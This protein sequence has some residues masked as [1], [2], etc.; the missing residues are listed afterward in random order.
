MWP[1]TVVA[2]TGEL[3][4]GV[5]GPGDAERW[6]VVGVDDDVDLAGG[7]VV[8]DEGDGEPRGAGRDAAATERWVAGV[9]EVGLAGRD[10]V[11]GEVDVDVGDHASLLAGV[12]QVDGEDPLGPV[13]EGVVVR[14]EAPAGVL[15]LLG[16]G[17]RRPLL[18]FTWEPEP[19]D[20][21]LVLGV[22]VHVEVVDVLAPDRDDPI[23]GRQRRHGDLEEPV[24]VEVWHAEEAEPAGQRERALVA[25]IDQQGG[26]RELAVLGEEVEQELNR[27]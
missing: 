5:E 15:A 25:R 24:S 6:G 17:H 21:L 12:D 7:G 2:A 18:T 26:G 14:L 10:V 16:G 19:P 27:P 20:L 9:G 22:E 23:G 11:V 1:R 8:P 3:G 4:G 13:T